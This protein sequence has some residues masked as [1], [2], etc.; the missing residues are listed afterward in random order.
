M[1]SKRFTYSRRME[2]LL[3]GSADRGIRETGAWHERILGGLEFEAAGRVKRVVAREP[4][5]FD[6]RSWQR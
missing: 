5:S 1:S 4:L 3:A 6:E 2:S